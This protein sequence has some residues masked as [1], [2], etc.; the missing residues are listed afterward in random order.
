[1]SPYDRVPPDAE[2]GAPVPTTPRPRCDWRWWVLPAV[3]QYLLTYFLLTVLDPCPDLAFWLRQP[4]SFALFPLFVWVFEPIVFIIVMTTA[5]LR[6][7]IEVFGSSDPW[8]VIPN[9]IALGCTA[10][11]GAVAWRARSK[12]QPTRPWVALSAIFM[13]LLV[14]N[15]QLT[16]LMC[17]ASSA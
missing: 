1:M 7:G 9:L 16:R 12:G 13:L 4:I 17:H 10:V 2:L 5:S 8:F 3:P 14:V 15:L 11:L 6:L